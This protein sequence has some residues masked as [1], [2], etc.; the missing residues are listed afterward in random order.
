VPFTDGKSS[1]LI[2]K[3]L[4]MPVPLTSKLLFAITFPLISNLPEG[5]KFPIPTFPLLLI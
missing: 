5:D 3:E 2:T 4:N 1:P